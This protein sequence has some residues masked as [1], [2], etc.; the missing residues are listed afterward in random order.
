MWKT[1]RASVRFQTSAT[2]A[3]RVDPIGPGRFPPHSPLV[4][5]GAPPGLR[6]RGDG[7]RCVWCG[8]FGGGAWFAA[9]EIALAAAEQ[10]TVRFGK[11]GW[12]EATVV[13]AFRRPLSEHSFVSCDGTVD[14]FNIA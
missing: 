8:R 11:D 5:G 10:L 1:A 6:V 14:K 3:Q 4:A 12:T 13:P 7:L 9:H 2:L